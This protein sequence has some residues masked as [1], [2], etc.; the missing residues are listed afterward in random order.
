MA[1]LAGW[2]LEVGKKA[3]K[4]HLASMRRFVHFSLSLSLSLSPYPLH[5]WIGHPARRVERRRA[6]LRGEL[7]VVRSG[8]PTGSNYGMANIIEE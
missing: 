7:V 3:K 8:A 2:N 1:H 5:R 4:L 6:V